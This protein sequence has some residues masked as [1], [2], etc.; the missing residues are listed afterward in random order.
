MNPLSPNLIEDILNRPEHQW[1][2]RENG[3]TNRPDPCE[4]G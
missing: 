3:P 4:L 2:E 1:F